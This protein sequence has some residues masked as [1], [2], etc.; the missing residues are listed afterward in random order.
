MGCGHVPY[1]EIYRP[2]VKNVICV[3]WPNSRHEAEFLDLAADL[4]DPLPFASESFDTVLLTDVLEHI[5]RPA[6]L[7][8]EAARILRPDGKAIIAVPF[9]YWVHEQPHDF[10]RFTEFA[11]RRMCDESGLAIV[12][13]VPYG[14][15]PEV[16]VDVAGKCLNGRL[17]SMCGIYSAAM[18]VVLGLR[19][20]RYVST[21]TAPLFPL[22]YILVA[23]KRTERSMDN[24][25]TPFALSTGA[26]AEI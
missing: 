5:F 1:Y 21:R 15:A 26:R 8:S 13:L 25:R 6:E 4:N 2:F 20:F 14:G 24:A 3:D 9:L 7:I 18:S 10:Y 11:L 19:P 17:R 22:G 12:R 16:L 23:E